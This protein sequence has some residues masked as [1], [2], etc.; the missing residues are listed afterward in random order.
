MPPWTSCTT[1][2]VGPGNPSYPPPNPP[3]APAS[4]AS[5]AHPP[6]DIPLLTKMF[7]VVFLS[8]EVLL[9]VVS[10]FLPPEP[11]SRKARNSPVCSELQ[12]APREGSEEERR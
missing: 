8:G 3:A 11:L 9:G 1:L 5:L 4:R 7:H 10:F 12:R 6:Q 2:S